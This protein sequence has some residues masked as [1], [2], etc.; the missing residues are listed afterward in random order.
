[1]SCSNTQAYR[2]DQWNLEAFQGYG[3]PTAQDVLD[4][5]VDKKILVTSGVCSNQI[6]SKTEAYATCQ[7][8]LEG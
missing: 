6:G 8:I 5:E 2:V 7:K 3:I 1:L 4:H